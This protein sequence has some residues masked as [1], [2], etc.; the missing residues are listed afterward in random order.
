GRSLFRFD[1]V[2]LERFRTAD[3]SFFPRVS[4]LAAHPDGSLWVGLHSGGLVRLSNGQT[5]SFGVAEGVPA[6]YSYDLAI[7]RSGI[8]VAAVAE[9]LVIG[10]EKGW[11]VQALAGA[12]ADPKI[13]SVLVDRDGGVWAGGAQ[14]W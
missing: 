3:G 5:R 14:L 6:G 11:H 2:T 7:D 13:R 8:V 4:A 10:G 1:G 9:Q 12:E